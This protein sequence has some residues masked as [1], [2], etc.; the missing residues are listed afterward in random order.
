MEHESKG[1][2]ALNDAARKELALALLARANIVADGRAAFIQ[3][4]PNTAKEALY[5]ATHHIYVDGV[6]GVLTFLADAELFIRDP[7]NHRLDRAP[8]YELLYHLYNWLT[9]RELLPTGTQYVLG[10]LNDLQLAVDEDDRNAIRATAGEL[11]DALE[12]H[13]NYPDFE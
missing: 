13:R 4:Y 5:T 2:Y 8:T 7:A 11:R 3:A 10:L 12:G 6:P 9:F 1:V